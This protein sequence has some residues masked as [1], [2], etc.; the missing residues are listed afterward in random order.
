MTDYRVIYD[1]PLAPD[2]PSS[3]L[4]PSPEWMADA[5]AGMLPP[6]S[7]YWALHDAE[8][9]AIL[10][11]RHKEFRHAQDAF[12]LQFNNSKIG[13]LSERE[14]IEYLI[15][16]DVPRRVWGHKHNRPMFAIVHKDQL[17]KTREFRNAWRMSI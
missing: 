7:A 15:L 17:P 13:P 9:K 1:D 14:A 10:D 12:D 3:V 8:Q 5:M 4:V 16:K 2:E 6:I 11:G